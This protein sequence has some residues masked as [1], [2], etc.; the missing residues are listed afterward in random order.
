M[1]AQIGSNSNITGTS[2]FESNGT[3]GIDGDTEVQVEDGGGSDSMTQ[4]R[5]DL[6][7]QDACSAMHLSDILDAPVTLAPMSVWLRLKLRADG[8]AANADA[9]ADGPDADGPDADGSGSQHAR[10]RINVTLANGT[11]ASASDASH[12]FAAAQ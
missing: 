6:W 3:D 10:S 8:P 1:D 7:R 5:S 4:N 9:D 12:G 11:V 2:G